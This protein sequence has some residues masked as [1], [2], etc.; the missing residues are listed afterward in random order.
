MAGLRQ[1]TAWLGIG[2]FLLCVPSV[3]CFTVAQ[4][5]PCEANGSVYYVG[6]WYILHSEHCT[7]CECTA[8]GPVCARTECT[9]LPDACIHVSHYPTECC[10]RCEEIGCEYQGEVYEFGQNFQPSECELCFCEKEGTICQVADCAPPACVNPVYQKGICCP[11][12]KDGPNCYVDDSRTQ[13]IPGGEAVWVDSCT[14]CQCHDG[15]D[16]SYWKDNR[17]ATRVATCTRLQ[18]CTVS[19][20]E[21][22]NSDTPHH[23]SV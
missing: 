21:N 6:E 22:K 13:I 5:V 23:Q 1:L 9:A 2:A 10:P 15:E 12:C 4:D 14:K 3:F 20:G 8:K 17:V 11:D 19:K 7:Q 16:V 18:N